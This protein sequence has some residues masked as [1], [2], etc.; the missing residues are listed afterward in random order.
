[1]VL[2]L[3]G[4]WFGRNQALYG[5]PLAQKAFDWYFS[6]TPTW[7]LFRDQFGFT[8]GRYL[9]TK[10]YRT[11]FASFWGAF[12]HLNPDRPELFMGAIGR[13]YPPRSW[14]YPILG[15]ALIASVAGGV[16]HLL[17]RR[18]AGAELPPDQLARAGVV[19]LHVV[20]VFA[21]FLRFNATYFQAQGR[22]LFPAIGGIA[23]ALA[24]GWLEWGRWGVKRQTSNVNRASREVLHVSRF[25]FHAEGALAGLVVAGMLS[26]AVYA[27]LG[28]IR[29]AF[30]TG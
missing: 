23:L 1:V 13:G 18:L 7:E 9:Y 8:Y 16:L 11:S 20:F 26:L 2:V 17:R 12:G 6:D 19:A 3:S 29:P 22:Y 10:V 14:L 5:D 30:G 27:L 25:T 15:W 24:A 21:A 28:T 4:W